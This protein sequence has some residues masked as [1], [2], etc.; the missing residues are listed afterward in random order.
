[1]T[2]IDNEVEIGVATSIATFLDTAPFDEEAALAAVLP[3]LSSWLGALIQT[4]LDDEPAWPLD[5]VMDD[6]GPWWVRYVD[7]TTVELAG[8][9]WL[10]NGVADSAQP[11]FAGTITLTPSRDRLRAY[12][13][14]F[15]D[16]ATGT[17]PSNVRERDRRDWP[18]VETW[19]FTFVP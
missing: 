19:L 8:V 6:A 15:G 14:T 12:R 3:D 13:L 11:P 2:R 7:S 17:D 18:N 10:L 4:H 1:M 5:W 9:A 16:A